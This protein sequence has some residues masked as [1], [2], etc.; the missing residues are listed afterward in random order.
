[1]R[2]DLSV[3]GVSELRAIQEEPE[4]NDDSDAFE[5]MK[6]REGNRVKRKRLRCLLNVPKPR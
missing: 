3:L 1:M 4:D 5:S 2:P 6:P